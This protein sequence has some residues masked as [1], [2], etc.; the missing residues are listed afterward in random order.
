MSLLVIGSGGG[1]GG[2]GRV[3]AADS[4]GKHDAASFPAALMFEEWEVA[5]LGKWATCAFV[6][7]LKAG[8]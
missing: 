3:A 4:G 7:S 2:G 1:C 6:I 8:A 5:V